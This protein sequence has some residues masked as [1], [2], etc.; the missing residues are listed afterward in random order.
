M[1]YLKRSKKEKNNMVPFQ[2]RYWIWPHTLVNNP[3]F[4]GNRLKFSSGS[5][6]RSMV[7]T[8]LQCASCLA[9]LVQFVWKSF[10]FR[11]SR[12]YNTYE[13]KRWP[14]GENLKLFR[15]WNGI[16][17]GC[18]GSEFCQTCTHSAFYVGEVSHFQVR[19]R[20][21]KSPYIFHTILFTWV[22]RIS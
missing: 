1:M 20:N 16:L 14:P 3:S 2:N 6:A 17:H 8:R 11:F 18:F 21:L 7:R 15:N 10:K 9:L 13:E 12:R 22:L 5:V 19:V 4:S